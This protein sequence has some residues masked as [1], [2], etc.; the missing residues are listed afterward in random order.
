MKLQQLKEAAYF[1]SPTYYSITVSGFP[2]ESAD[3]Y[4]TYL[5]A[6]KSEEEA[7]DII[8]KDFGIDFSNINVELIDDDYLEDYGVN[9]VQELIGQDKK[10]PQQRGKYIQISYGT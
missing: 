10:L 4:E 5:I 9:S 2:G 3:Y 8:Q 6:A 1:K 7:E